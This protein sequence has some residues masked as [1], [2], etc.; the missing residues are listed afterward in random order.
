MLSGSL[1]KLWLW[2]VGRIT[3]HLYT[4]QINETT[5]LMSLKQFC[6]HFQVSALIVKLSSCQF[7]IQSTSSKAVSAE[8]IILVFNSAGPPCHRRGIKLK[9]VSSLNFL[10]ILLDFFR[11]GSLFQL[12]WVSDFFIPHNV[13]FLHSL[14]N[15]HR[16][17]PDGSDLILCHTPAIPVH[18]FL[19][20]LLYYYFTSKWSQLINQ[21]IIFNNL[22]IF[23]R[24]VQ[25]HKG[26][27]SIHIWFCNCLS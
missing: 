12:S 16:P 22:S 5:A 27:L 4:V 3:V 19:F 6:L 24:F 2:C 11:F 15:E 14:T 23:I 1:L 7:Q 9:Q 8:Q 13:L 10:F 18:V 17:V 26:S 20:Q 25:N 21:N